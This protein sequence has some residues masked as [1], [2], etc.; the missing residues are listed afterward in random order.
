VYEGRLGGRCHGQAATPAPAQERTRGAL[1]ARYSAALADA[2]AECALWEQLRLHLPAPAAELH[3]QRDRLRA[4]HANVA[5]VVRGYNQARRASPPALAR[6]LPVA[7]ASR[8]S[9]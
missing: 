8:G 4:L 3:A 2:G 7:S 5:A 6:A 1:S 9:A